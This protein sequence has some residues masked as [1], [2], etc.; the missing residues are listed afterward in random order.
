MAHTAVH[1]PVSNGD[2]V[3][4]GE[5][6]T[7]FGNDCAGSSAMVETLRVELARFNY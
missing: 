3:I 1:D 6:F 7:H 2:E 4:S 5:P